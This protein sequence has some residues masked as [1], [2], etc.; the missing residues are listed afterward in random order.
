MYCQ[1]CNSRMIEINGIGGTSEYQCQ[2][3]SCPSHYSHIKCPNCSSNDKIVQQMGI[4][5]QS[6]KCKNCQ[7]EWSS[8]DFI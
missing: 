5:D 1:H 6:F 3:G 8:L 2:N 4:G 7:Q